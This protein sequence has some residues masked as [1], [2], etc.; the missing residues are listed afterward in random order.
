MRFREWVLEIFDK[1]EEGC[2]TNFAGVG[3]V[4]CTACSDLP[5]L[6]LVPAVSLPALPSAEKHDIAQF[7]LRTSDNRRQ[8]HDGFHLVD[9]KCWTICHAFQY[10]SPPIPRKMQSFQPSVPVGARFTTALLASMLPGVV[11]VATLNSQ[12]Q[13]SLF[14]EGSLVSL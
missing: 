6:P 13:A 14:E 4:L 9:V 7:L 5:K 2:P 11:A 10:L 3:I 8:I 1:V 12:F